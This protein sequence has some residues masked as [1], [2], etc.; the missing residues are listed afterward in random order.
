MSFI[1][2]LSLLDRGMRL[3]VW[4]FLFE[5][6][7]R[8][9]CNTSAPQEK[10]GYHH[11]VCVLHTS[12]PSFQESLKSSEIEKWKIEITIF[13]AASHRVV[14]AGPKL[15]PL[16]AFAFWILGLKIQEPGGGGEDTPL[17]PALVPLSTENSLPA[18]GSCSFGG[19]LLGFCKC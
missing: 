18:V 12:H 8:H 7:I 17:I 6:E 1:S 3:S 5:V 16:P 19:P 13:E 9:F 15:R 11:H 14:Q 4:M 2:L 10:A